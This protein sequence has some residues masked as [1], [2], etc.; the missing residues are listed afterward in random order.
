[1]S[2]GLVCLSHLVHIFLSLE[3]TAFVVVGSNDLCTK[4]F[5][6]RVAGTLAGVT[7]EVLHREG[8]FPLRT[9]LCRHLE[10]CTTY[11]T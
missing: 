3:C 2:K 10:V 5:C 6:H 11:T 4:F 1:M 9:Q 7:D 8:N